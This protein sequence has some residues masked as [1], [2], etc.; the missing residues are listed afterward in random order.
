MRPVERLTPARNAETGGRVNTDPRT[1]DAVNAY[2]GRRRKRNVLSCR[3]V[4]LDRVS[5]ILSHRAL[6]RKHTTMADI[7]T[8][9]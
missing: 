9:R 6:D 5:D 2:L 3:A 4:V 7:N 1:R 8:R